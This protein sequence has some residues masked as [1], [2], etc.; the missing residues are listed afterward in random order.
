MT[1]TTAPS[2][3]ARA[4]D[5]APRGRVHRACARCCSSRA[6]H[7]RS[8][9]WRRCCGR[10]SGSSPS[11]RSSAR[12]RRTSRIG[13]NP[14]LCLAAGVALA[15]T[16][17]TVAAMARAATP[18]RRSWCAWMAFAGYVV[19][20]IGFLILARV[21]VET[22]SR[23]AFLDGAVIGTAM[24]MLLWVSLI[25]PMHTEAMDA[26]HRITPRDGPRCA[27]AC[28]WRS[29]R[30]SRS[31]P[32]GGRRRCGCSRSRSRSCSSPTSP[33]STARNF[34]ADIAVY[35][36]VLRAS[37]WALLGLAALLSPA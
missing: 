25:A 13:T 23:T 2:L 30:G 28:S 14:W 10:S 31:R 15:V 11:R 34:D 9:R 6:R 7:R 17:A 22:A 32:V 18:H 21:T 5:R 16:A 36:D 1:A 27:T 20:G 26:A 8:A 24:V 3:P 37:A 35:V 4:P 19:L 12:A 33:A 29:S